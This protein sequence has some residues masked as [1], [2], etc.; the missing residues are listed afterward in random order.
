VITEERRIALR[1]ANRKSYIK[2]REKRLARNKEWKEKN[3]ERYAFLGRRWRRR[4]YGAIDPSGETKT[5]PC[6]ICGKIVLLS[7]DHDHNT[8]LFRGW[9][10][11]H[12]NTSFEWMLENFKSAMI[13]TKK[14]GV[15]L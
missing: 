2:H 1:A 9:L 8:K 5:G 14:T 3:P 15:E 12:C 6:E 7:Y 11:P 4:K 13:Y 10:C